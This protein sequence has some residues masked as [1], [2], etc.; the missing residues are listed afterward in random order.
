MASIDPQNLRCCTKEFSASDEEEATL[1][2]IFSTRLDSKRT[3][4]GR[5]LGPVKC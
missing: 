1:L 2:P 5:I 4:T 3:L